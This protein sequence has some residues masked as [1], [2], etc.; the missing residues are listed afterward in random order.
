MTTHQRCLNGTIN[1]MWLVCFIGV[2]AATGCSDNSLPTGET[3]SVYPT[4]AGRWAGTAREQREP[5]VNDYMEYQVTA[6]FSQ[7]AGT[8]GGTWVWTITRMSGACPTVGGT[9]RCRF[10]G[11]ID[12]QGNITIRDT[13]VAF[14]NWHGSRWTHNGPIAAALSPRGDTIAG[15]GYGKISTTSNNA[16]AIGKQ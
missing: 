13:S 5:T 16:F 6:D 7:D 14:L 10:A 1:R 9:T 15:S 3:N 2:L 8:L 12:S 4:V 11:S